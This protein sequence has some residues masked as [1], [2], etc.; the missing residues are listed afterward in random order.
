MKRRG[1][2]VVL[3]LAALAAAPAAGAPE[4]T[5]RRGG[6]VVIGP[7]GELSCLN[8]LDVDCGLPAFLGQVLEPAFEFT[9]DF[10]LR[11]RLVST[12]SYTRTPP[13]TVTFGIH[14]DARWSDRVP[15]TARD[16]VFTHDAMAKHLAPADQHVH[17][18]V[19]DV[20]V[21]DAKTVRVVLRS[22]TAAIR[23]LFPRVLPSHALRGLDLET[24]WRERIDNPRTGAPIG[25][26]PFLFRSWER[27]RQM[28]FVRNPNYWGPHTAYLHRIVFRFCSSPC[29][30]PPP[31]EV[32]GALRQGHV[33]MTQSRDPAIIDELRRIPGTKVL[34]SRLNALDLLQLRLGPGGHPALRNKL[35]RRALAYGIDRSAIART[36]LGELDPNY[37]ASDNAVLLRTDRHYR[38]N[39]AVYRHRPALARRLLE[40]AGCRLG[41]DRIYSCAGERLTLRFFT[42]AN[43]TFRVRTL[44][45]IERQLRQVG[46]DV[47]LEFTPPRVLFQQIAPS[48]A[49]DAVEFAFFSF[50]GI[51]IDVYGC[52]R[53][54]NYTDY[55][56]RLVIADLDQSD[57]ILDVARRARVL[58]RA[59]ARIAKDVPVIPLYQTPNVIAFRN[60]IQN[61]V[62][63]SGHE[64]WNAENWWLA[65]SR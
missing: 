30:L 33:D 34:A 38:P 46:V 62:S 43:A 19:R 63:A 31:D 9:P 61:V 39:W 47:E 17:R 8:P 50:R 11:P 21:L 42:I 29:G 57:R 45:L 13:Y 41:V 64:L 14:P 18:L 52:Q 25:D 10:T 65:E 36:V 22:R 40:Q 51:G 6:T 55:C 12:V 49:F 5:P 23:E 15:V 3:V 60:T 20:R 53:P 56:S 28:T 48:G 59:D 32:L 16:F 58:N 4:Q 27:G 1:F 24:I 44:E 2:I 7:G 54:F 26:G 37:P 35:V